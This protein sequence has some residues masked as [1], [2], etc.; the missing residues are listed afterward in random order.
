MTTLPTGTVT[1]LFSDI[2][3]STRLA[4]EH[5]EALAAVLSRHHA[6]L[7][8]AIECHAGYV[9]NII[10]DAF[11]SAF[12]T[13]GEA[14]EA[15]LDA[16]RRLAAERWSPAP[17]FVRMGISTGSA[18]VILRE[19][20]PADYSGYLT[21]AR[22]QR[23][24]S[25]AYGGQVLLSAASAELAHGELPAGVTLRDMGEHRLK[26]LVNPEHLWQLTAPDLRL[27][28]PPLVSLNAIPSNLPLQVTSFVGRESELAQVH[29]LLEAHRLVTLTGAGGSGKTRLALQAAADALDQ[30]RDGAWFVELAPVSDPDLIVPT[31]LH[32]FALLAQPGREPMD[33]LCEHLSGK[34][35]LL[36]LD[37]CEHL[38]DGC[39][40][41]TQSL[42]QASPRLRIV[43]TSREALN[44]PGEQTYRVPSLSLPDV[45][46]LPVLDQL[47]QYE[48]V[49]LFIERALLVQPG[50]AIDN[51]N[52]PAVAQICSRL[53]GIPLA[54]ELA[55]VRL[56]SM[57]LEVIL[58]RLDDRFRL[59]IGGSRVALP[60]QQTLRAMID[61]SYALL[62]PSEQALLKRLSVFR[63]GCSL[64]AA[65]AVCC[66]GGI[67]SVDV[68]DLLSRLVD[69]SLLSLDEKGRYRVLETVRQYGVERLAES[70]DALG[71]HDCH[72]RYLL[73][74][75]EQA[76][77]EIRGPDQVTWLARLDAEVDNLRA[78]LSW[79][80]E[81]D[82]E[83]AMR[84]AAALWRYWDLRT[85]SLE[86]TDWL[87]K[88]LAH[89]GEMRT[90]ARA[91]C[92]SALCYFR[93]S[94]LDMAGAR[95][96]GEQA[97]ALAT[98]L[99][100]TR[101]AVMV[102]LE[103]AD[104]NLPADSEWGPGA[105]ERALALARQTGDHWLVAYSVLVAAYAARVR[106]DIPR[107]CSLYEQAVSEAKACGDQQLIVVALEQLSYIKLALADSESADQLGQEAQDIAERIGDVQGLTMWSLGR[108]MLDLTREQYVQAGQHAQEAYDLAEAHSMHG[109]MIF[110]RWYRAI[111]AWG[112]G[113]AAAFV[114]RARAAVSEA[115][116]FSEPLF[117]FAG[118]CR[119]GDAF[120]LGGDRPAARESYGRAL[121][122]VRQARY[123]TA[124]C[125]CLQA[126]GGLAVRD[127][128]AASGVRLF[129]ARAR[130][131]ETALPEDFWPPL[132]HD[133][134][135]L[136]ADAR[137]ELG[138]GAFAAAWTAG[139]ALDD[140]EALGLAAEIIGNRATM[141]GV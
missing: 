36:I 90:V 20:R 138:E 41:I 39:C 33:I 22:V 93:A 67:E 47:T 131:R 32:T 9:F 82:P 27:D 56:K 74:L 139:Q 35:L 83:A 14:V 54:I 59:L 123:A 68:L 133:R 18:Q 92:L 97:Y 65:E 79:G 45:H 10:G 84:L 119:L 89:A 110:A 104:G 34:S 7:Q 42:L 88:A 117:L 106:N 140:D 25:V 12:H 100:D 75:A 80:L 124:V 73:R 137:A 64:E 141:S 81:R 109:N 44:L 116:R 77:P 136:L 107:A 58:A 11:C 24:M 50:F 63:G 134:E 40:R 70:E 69:K 17:I 43:A 102:L 23:V 126:I 60:R 46:R 29:A 98:E 13:V 21:L 86:A 120:L 72:L 26:S 87:Q 114:E 108:A 62:S 53:D 48:A 127:G 91:R 112:L 76:E 113:D 85:C 19:G 130:R 95:P 135:K 31:M 4:Q 105:V 28:F 103:L 8:D 122:I 132:V 49:R 66:G 94:L 52:A 121:D 61:W 71:A 55:A 15:A 96:I 6:I 101:S 5:P 38:L 125:T 129:A 30:F 51:A 16:Q 118:L 78:A 1:F 99:G 37:N 128:Q 57:P 115:E 3:G 111:A 2:E